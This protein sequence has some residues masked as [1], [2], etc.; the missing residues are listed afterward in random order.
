MNDVEIEEFLAEAEQL[1]LL[2][3]VQEALGVERMSYGEIC[4]HGKDTPGEWVPTP[5]CT[6]RHI[7][8]RGADCCILLAPQPSYMDRGK[9]LAFLE[10]DPGAYPERL[11]VE[12]RVD[13]WPRYYF[14]LERAKLECE[15]WLLA[16][17]QIQPRRPPP[18]PVLEIE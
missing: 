6:A 8:I 2:Y 17:N 18:L 16:R 12:W 1:R 5:Q 10:V 11:H 7:Q 9:W 4:Q 15:A 13:Q 14:D 3:Q